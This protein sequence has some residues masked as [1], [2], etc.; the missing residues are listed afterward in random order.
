MRKLNF[1]K[2][3]R[4]KIAEIQEELKTCPN[5][6]TEELLELETNAYDDTFSLITP[7]EVSKEIRFSI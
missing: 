6:E 1:P 7:G 5:P 3:I 2:K 4:D